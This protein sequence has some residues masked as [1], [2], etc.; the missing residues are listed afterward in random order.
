GAIDG[1]S[2]PTVSGRLSAEAALQKLIADSGLEVLSNDGRTIILQVAPSAHAPTAAGRVVAAN[3][4]AATVL[5]EVIVRGAPR[6]GTLKRDSDTVVSTI[7]ELEIKRLP[8]LDISDALARVPG[9]RR[10]DTQSGENR[11]VSIRGLNN[12]AASQSID[13]VLLTNYVNTSRAN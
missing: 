11:Y 4:E 5:E 3:T 6:A 13:G 2:A 1:R 12:A 7:T 9:V 10:N 8:T